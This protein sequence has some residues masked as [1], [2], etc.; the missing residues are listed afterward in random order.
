M[1]ATG[2]IEHYAAAW[3]YDQQPLVDRAWSQP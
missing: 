1:T 3:L 2:V